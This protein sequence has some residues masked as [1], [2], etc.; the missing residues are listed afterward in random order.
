MKYLTQYLTTEILK[1][2]VRPCYKLDEF[3]DKK[4]LK[5]TLISNPNGIDLAFVLFNEFEMKDICL[6][7]NL[8]K[9]IKQKLEK[10]KIINKWDYIYSLSRN[11][12]AKYIFKKKK[13]LIDYEELAENRA[14]WP[15]KIYLEYAIKN[16]N[17]IKYPENV[18]KN[19]FIFDFVKIDSNNMATYKNYT[20]PVDFEWLQTNPHPKALELL[21]KNNIKF[22][23]MFLVENT[24]E[25]ALKYLNYEELDNLDFN[26][27]NDTFCYNPLLYN[28]I[29][30]QYNKI[31]ID[32]YSLSDNTAIFNKDISRTW[33]DLIK[34]EN[35]V[36]K[37]I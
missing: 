29:K 10:N 14:K 30:T 20:I 17:K 9:F 26:Y 28:Y 32:W 36:Y 7:P 31:F 13:E 19:P 4:K 16:H 23:V 18:W 22:N 24:N 27:I 37:N 35:N 1:Y 6:N 34:I 15:L 11:P 12:N 5:K 33:K 2:I 3:I 21:L 8:I 25:E